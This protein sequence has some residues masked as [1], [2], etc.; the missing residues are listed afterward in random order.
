MKIYKFKIKGLDYASE[1][2]SPLQKIATGNVNI[3]FTGKRN[4]SPL[5]VNKDATLEIIKKVIR[6]N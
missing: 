2:E 4:T 3:N 1:L 6:K 5:E